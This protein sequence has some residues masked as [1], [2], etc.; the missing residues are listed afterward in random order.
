MAG[1]VRVA[2][3]HAE[4]KIPNVALTP[5]RIPRQRHHP[6]LQSQHSVTTAAT[7]PSTS[8]TTTS[9]RATEVTLAVASG[10]E[11]RIGSPAAAMAVRHLE[12]GILHSR[13]PTLSAPP[14]R[15]L[16]SRC[17]EVAAPA[18]I[19]VDAPSCSRAP[20]LP[21]RPSSHL[22][23]PSG[24]ISGRA[25]T[26]AAVGVRIFAGRVST[27]RRHGDA[28]EALPIASGCIPRA[29]GPEAVDVRPA[30]GGRSQPGASAPSWPIPRDWRWPA[31]SPCSS[32]PA[33][34]PMW[35]L[36]PP[37]A[38]RPG[39]LHRTERRQTDDQSNGTEHGR[40]RPRPE[41]TA[42]ADPHGLARSTIYVRVADGSFPQPIRLGARAV[43]WIE[44]EVDAWIR[45]QIAASRGNAK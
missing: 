27:G 26:D 23:V 29:H 11:S 19:D 4:L 21:G 28:D 18:H 33:A 16:P 43:G 30:G 12:R 35:P 3:D 20:R 31:R 22:E 14:W 15:R 32:K 42:S 6:G 37:G 10:T 25:R 44:S 45:E 40:A 8:R 38:T 24:T 5:G 41:V 34:G 2:L 1:F 39:I 7:P 13:G 36:F 9:P 17:P